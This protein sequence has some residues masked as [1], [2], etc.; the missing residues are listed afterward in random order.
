M[1]GVILLHAFP[2]SPQMWAPQI[3]LLQERY[4]VW[5]PNILGQPSLEQAA[6]T[7]LDKMEGWE[8]AV[9]GLSMGG[10]TAFR[11][12]ELAPERV[13]GL[14]LADTRA[15]A[16]SDENKAARAQQAE[17]IRQEGIGWLPEALLKSHLGATTHKERP[18]VGAEASRMILEADPERIIHSLSALANRAD[19]RLL[20]PTIQVPTLVLV[21]EE[22]TLTPP[23]EARYLASAIP[24]SRLLIVPDAGHMSSLENPK[25]FNT[26]LLGFLAEVL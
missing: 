18:S 14:V 2:Y 15:G 11:M 26:A 13:A 3:A 25:A 8:Q 9:V 5:A 19:S 7:V 23:S 1:T 17:R 10:Y 21:G 6:K 12:W 24:D 22:D 16:D 20:L 4:P